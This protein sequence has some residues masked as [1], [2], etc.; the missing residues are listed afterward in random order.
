MLYDGRKEN[1]DCPGGSRHR[2]SLEGSVCIQTPPCK[3][4]LT[5]EEVLSGTS[6][7]NVSLQRGTK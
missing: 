6:D 4:K 2:W 3:R 1:Q 7:P 5:T